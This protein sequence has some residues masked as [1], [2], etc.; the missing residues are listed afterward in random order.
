LT[1]FKE[2]L[3]D[4]VIR[5]EKAIA[6]EIAQYKNSSFYKP[7]SYAVEGGKRIRPLVLVLSAES[8]SKKGGNPYPAA[9]AVELLHTESLIHDDVID[10]ES[11]RR[12][13]PAFH[14]KYGEQVAILSADFMFAVVVDILT[15]YGKPQILREIASSVL[16]MCEGEI[17]DFKMQM[18]QDNFSW[19][20]YINLIE[21]K[22][23]SLFSAAARIGAI[24]GEGEDWEIKTLSD[25]GRLFGV[26]YQIK[27]DLLD[28][29]KGERISDVLRKLMRVGS[30]EEVEVHLMEMAK[31][32]S[33]MAIN[34]LKPLKNTKAKEYLGELAKFS[35][36]R[37]F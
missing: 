23:A 12:G 4:Y 28:L 13:K 36:L 31:K 24:I 14:V 5:I 20:T 33:E 22:T 3:K 10:R 17:V 8:T 7:L 26:S 29:R 19:E 25:F 2:D 35:V 16:E 30:Y 32:Y 9:V 34:T 1:D 15:R 18:G 37:E 11:F 6:E 21:K 27:D